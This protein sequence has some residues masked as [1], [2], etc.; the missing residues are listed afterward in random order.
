MASTKLVK[1]PTIHF[2]NH[3][4]LKPNTPLPE[5]TKIQVFEALQEY[6][7]FEAIYDKV[8]NDVREGMFGF[9]KKIFE[10]PLETKLKNIS[11]KPMHGYM[12]MLPQLPFIETFANIFW[13]HGNH[14]FQYVHGRKYIFK[15]LLIKIEKK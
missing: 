15:I 6:G 4:E 5:S 12:G 11:E 1:V 14:H 8:P 10:F 13:P 9:L 3:Q 7:R 2:S